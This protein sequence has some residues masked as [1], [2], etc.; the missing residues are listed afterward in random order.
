VITGKLLVSDVPIPLAL[1]AGMAVGLAIGLINA[2]G[3]AK[4]GIPPFIVTLAGLQTYRGLALL[5]TGA[6]SIGAC[7]TS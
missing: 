2:A 6:Q 3:V 7:R 5:T 1:T 4:L